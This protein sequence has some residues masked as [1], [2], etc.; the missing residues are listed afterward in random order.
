MLLVYNVF[1]G[2]F[3]DTYYIYKASNIINDKVYIG[4]TKHFNERVKQHLVCTPAED[5]EFHRALEALGKE[6][7]KFEVIDTADGIEEGHRLEREYIKKYDSFRNGYNSTIGGYAATPWNVKPIVCLDLDGN[8]VK[9]Y[10]SAG[11]AKKDGFSDSNVLECCKGILRSCMKHIFMFEEDYEKSGPKKYE[12]P[13]PFNKTPVVQCDMDGN[14]I[15]RFASIN[16]A[17][18][19]TGIPRP[20]ISASVTGKHKSAYGCIFV[21]ETDFPIKDL[22]AFEK[23]KKGRRVAQINIDTGDVVKI[24]DRIADAGR[25]LGVSY[26]A[27]HKVVDKEDRSAYGFRWESR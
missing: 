19:E 7:F 26:K 10:E 23:K 11:E 3:V 13:V 14:L 25:E 17:A 8:F 18:D 2:D 5:C 6:N 16:E 24:Y 27:I 21:R 1:G 15:K 4:C 12:K 22:T 9:R 20:Q